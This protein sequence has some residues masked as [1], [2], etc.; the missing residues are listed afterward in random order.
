MLFP[1]LNYTEYCLFLCLLTARKRTQKRYPNR[2]FFISV[3]E[4]IFGFTSKEFLFRARQNEIAGR[5]VW[6]EGIFIEFFLPLVVVSA[7]TPTV[8]CDKIKVIISKEI[9]EGCLPSTTSSFSW[10]SLTSFGNMKI[11]ISKHS[12][13]P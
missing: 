9:L 3:S 11:K 6:K 8:W 7:N 12:I 1:T 2:N 10:L 13:P 4:A 5:V